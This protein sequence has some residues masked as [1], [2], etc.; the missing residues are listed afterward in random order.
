M[1]SRTEGG[2]STGM[3]GHGTPLLGYNICAV[4][5]LPCRFFALRA[6]AGLDLLA[7]QPGSSK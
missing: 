2:V 1:R 6:H 7:L 5:Q 3:H 4:K